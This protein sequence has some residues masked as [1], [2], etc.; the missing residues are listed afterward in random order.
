M[1]A[2]AGVGGGGAGDGGAGRRLARKGVGDCRVHEPLAREHAF[3]R[4]LRGPDFN[5]IVTTAA[6]DLDTGVRNPR[7]D[8]SAYR[9]TYIAREVCRLVAHRCSYSIARNRR[10]DPPPPPLHSPLPLLPLP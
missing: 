1:S 10:I 3:A 5:R 6:G 7:R 9:G 2:V 8:R 4:E